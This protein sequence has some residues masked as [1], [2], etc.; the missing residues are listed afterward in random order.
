MTRR[1][2]S[3]NR[4][5]MSVL[6]FAA[7]VLAASASA[8]GPARPCIA[9]PFR[10]FD[11]WAGAWE[12]HARGAVAG[13]SV[14]TIEEVGCVVRER[15]TS[16]TGATGQSSNYHDPVSGLWRQVWISNGLLID[17][18]GGPEGPG[19]MALEGRSVDLATGISTPFRGRW[20]LR[21]DGSVLQTLWSYNAATGSWD[22]WFEGTYRRPGGE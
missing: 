5:T 12:V 16:A 20:A 2:P 13:S 9:P 15:W 17:L 21:E 4:G 1:T 3:G 14:V 22:V 10:A 7:A 18:E 19:T 8:Q 11:F 6:A